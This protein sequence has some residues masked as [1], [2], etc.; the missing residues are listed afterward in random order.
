MAQASQ[1]LPRR[2]PS[3]GRVVGCSRGG[4]STSAVRHPRR[5]VNTSAVRHPR[6]GVNTSPIRHPRHVG[7]HTIS[8]GIS[9]PSATTE[10]TSSSAPAKETSSHS[11]ARAPAKAPPAKSSSS[12]HLNHLLFFILASGGHAC[13]LA[14]SP[15]QTG[16]GVEYMYHCT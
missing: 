9:P 8:I 16:A 3:I 15:I 5:G 6:R 12:R 2:I 7:A 4:V 10:P 1:S 11:P 14:A 13:L